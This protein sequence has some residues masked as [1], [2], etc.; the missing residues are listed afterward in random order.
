M[1]VDDDLIGDT[2]EKAV[3][4]NQFRLIT[5]GNIN[6]KL[7][8]YGATIIELG[9]AVCGCLGQSPPVA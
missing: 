6:G 5:A 3:A 1:G 4:N 8:A 7:G 9:K 2:V